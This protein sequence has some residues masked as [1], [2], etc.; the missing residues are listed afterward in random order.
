[1]GVEI[2]SSSGLVTK[3]LGSTVRSC[4]REPVTVS[5]SEPASGLTYKMV[6]ND[7]GAII[8]VEKGRPVGMIT[9]RDVLERVMMANKDVYGT[10]ARDVM[11]KPV[12]SIEADRSI[13]EALELMQKHKIRR[14]VATDKG[15]LIGIV[16]ERRLLREFLNQVI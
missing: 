14:L 1:M 4:V 11:S 8:V 10:E 15:T 7:I 16:T 12:I 13:K 5:P 9:E 6:G 2:L 3:A